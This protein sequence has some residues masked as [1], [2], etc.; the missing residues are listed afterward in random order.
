MG[1]ESVLLTPSLLY[2]L[3]PL[4][5]MKGYLQTLPLYRGYKRYG[6][7]EKERIWASEGPGLNLDSFTCCLYNPQQGLP[8]RSLSPYLLNGDK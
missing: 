7:L 3:S 6:I 8:S 1:I 5:H 2:C 4:S